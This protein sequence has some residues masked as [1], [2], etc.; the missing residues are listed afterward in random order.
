[1]IG[2]GLKPATNP[3]PTHSYHSYHSYHSKRME[4]NKT[5][6]EVSAIENGTVI[7]HI[8][9][10]SLFKVIS[11]LNLDMAT[12]QITFG[13]NL[14]SKRIGKKAIIKI[15]DK[16]CEDTEISY[17][18]LVAPTA[19]ISII[20]DYEVVVKRQIEAPE[21]VQGFVKCANPMCVTNHE[22]ITTHF[23]VHDQNGEL[24]LRCRYCEKITRQEQI[25]I[26]R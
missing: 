26:I 22:P 12:N 17:L 23:T 15:A 4:H 14:T 25:E 7:D 19:R 6:L 5:M 18:A 11:L 24:S 1:M 16:Y 3:L 20:K 13:T 2:V 21:T 9:A 8:P 10:A